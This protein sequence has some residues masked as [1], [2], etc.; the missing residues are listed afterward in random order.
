MI[1]RRRF[2]SGAVALIGGGSVTT[3]LSSCSGDA[4]Q[5]ELQ[6]VQRFPQVLVPGNV[7]IPVSLADNNGLLTVDAGVKLPATLTA[8]IVNVNTGEVVIGP[9]TAAQHSNGLSIPYY[10]FRAQIDDVG[11]YSIVIE[12]GQPDGAGIQIMDPSQIFIPLVGSVLPPFDTPTFGNPRG[13][14]PIC[15]FLPSACSLHNI[16]LTEALA[17]GKPIAYLVGTPA[18]CSTGTCSPAL[19]ALLQVSLQLGDTMSFVHAEIYTDD[20]ATVV[21]PAVQALNMSYEP[22]LFITDARGVIV[23]RLDAVFDADEINDVLT[24][25]GLS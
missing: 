16:T 19:D 5:S 12:G 6:I 7:R 8:N 23:D 2:I 4:V 1:S 22:A 14:D 20:T 13:V 3:A 17:L 18:H 15:T 24:A 9:L 11:V 10:P 21:A 25:L